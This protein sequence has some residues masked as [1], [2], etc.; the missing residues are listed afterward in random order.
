M[1]ALYPLTGI[2]EIEPG[3]DLAAILAN[4]LSAGGL[5]VQPGPNVWPAPSASGFK[6][7]A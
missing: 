6:H 7:E 1:I 5:R 2:G 3:A 4:A